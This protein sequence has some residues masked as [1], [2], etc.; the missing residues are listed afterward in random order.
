MRSWIL[1]VD[2]FNSRLSTLRGR[3]NG[4]EDGCQ[5]ENQ[6]QNS[7]AMHRRFKREKSRGEIAISDDRSDV[8]QTTAGFQGPLKVQSLTYPLE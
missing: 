2:A 5:L 1:T 3:S 4:I 6:P 8:K 7:D